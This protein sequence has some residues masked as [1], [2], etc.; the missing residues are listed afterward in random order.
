MS[1]H[2]I[3]I[4][5]RTASSLIW[6][7]P[8]WW[9][10]TDQIT[11][12]IKHTI[13]LCYGMITILYILSS[14]HTA[15]VWIQH[16]PIGVERVYFSNS[17]L[18]CLEPKQEEKCPTGKSSVS[19]AGQLVSTR[20]KSELSVNAWMADKERTARR[21]GFYANAAQFCPLVLDLLGLREANLNHMWP[22]EK[23]FAWHL[24]DWLLCSRGYANKFY[25]PQS[26]GK[27]TS[28]L[29]LTLQQIGHIALEDS[30]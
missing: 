20:R 11:A 5:S 21:R 8:N 26:R 10:L 24:D 14:Q 2:E 17:W 6:H 22:L 12:S 15:R 1:K 23:H 30:E 28:G 4:N 25:F 29:V 16:T 18:I 27:F 19:E 13:S 9:S 3:C 7:L